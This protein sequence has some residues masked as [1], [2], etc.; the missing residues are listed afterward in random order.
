MLKFLNLNADVHEVQ[1][2]TNRDLVLYVTKKDACWHHKDFGSMD[3][4]EQLQYIFTGEDRAANAVEAFNKVF[5][6]KD[7]K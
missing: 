5:P 4:P 3:I 6:K 2:H 1:I 7:K